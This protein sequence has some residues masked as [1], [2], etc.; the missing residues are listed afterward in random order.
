MREQPNWSNTLR[1]ESCGQT[2]SF[3]ENISGHYIPHTVLN[4]TPHIE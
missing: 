1:T 2:K 3:K 4:D